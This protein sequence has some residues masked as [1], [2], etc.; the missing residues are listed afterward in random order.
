[1]KLKGKH[2]IL[3]LVLLVSGFLIAFSYQHTKKESQVIQVTDQQWEKDFYYRQQLI[4]LEEKNKE[5]RD[6]LENKRKEIQTLES[7]LGGQT[8]TINNYVERKLQLQM[9]TGELPVHGEGVKVSLSDAEYVPSEE[10]ANQYIVHERH[11][12]RVVNELLSAG[13]EAVSING[14]RV[15]QDSY[16]SCVGPV[17]SVDGVTYPAPFTIE[18]IGDQDVL[19]SSI[20]LT[21]G[22]V[23]ELVSDNIEVEMERID[24][25]QM[26]TRV[27]KERG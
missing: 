7:E 11:I 8:D 4:N 1:M 14:Q 2:V 25:I 13:A 23:D 15:F 20:N 17:I 22:L 5:L 3:A 10:N 12:H 26:S 9:I 21:D 19:Y 18:A 24:A 16:I 27:N 6:E